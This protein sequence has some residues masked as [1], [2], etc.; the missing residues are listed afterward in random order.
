MIRLTYCICR[1]SQ[2]SLQNFISWC[3]KYYIPNIISIPNIK[4][5]ILNSNRSHSILTNEMPPIFNGDIS[6]KKEQKLKFTTLLVRNSTM[7]FEQ[8]TKHHKK[9]HIKLFSSVPIIQEK[10][11]R[12]T[13]SHKI[14]G[15]ESNFFSDKYDGIVEFWFDNPV[16]MLKIFINPTYLLRVRPDEKRFLELK[17][18][19]FVISK[20]FSPISL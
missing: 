14:T 5:N 11:R 8:F 19:N 16:D 4:R 7:S 15:L 12:Y 6:T 17:K 18:C 10:V 13:V 9:K 1:H 3:N 2:I 20:E